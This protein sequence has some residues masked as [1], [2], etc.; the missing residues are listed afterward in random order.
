MRAM[1]KAHQADQRASINSGFGERR[2]LAFRLSRVQSLTIVAAGIAFTGL[3][4]YA[5][6][7]QVWFGPAYLAFICLA[8]WVLGWRE[9]VAGL[10]ATSIITV[11]V[12]SGE[13]YP[14]GAAATVWDYAIRIP[15]V[16]A[17]IALL[18]HARHT[19]EREWRLARTDPLTGAMNRKAFF[20]LAGPI[21]N[22]ESWHV[23]AY[24]DLD[25]LKSLNDEHGHEQGDESLKVFSSHVR[26]MI[27]KDDIFARVGGDEFLVY[28]AVRDAHAGLTVT[29]RLHRAMNAATDDSGA[30]LCCSVGALILAPG[31]RSI[32]REL[33]AADE[34]MYEAKQTGSALTAAI[35]REENG[36]LVTSGRW[37]M[38]GAMVVSQTEDR[39]FSSHYR[40]RSESARAGKAAA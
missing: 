30:G 34:L 37:L 11:A 1:G 4:D 29:N 25:G 23:L 31:P 26:S 8:A 33:R 14:Y 7:D 16:L 9:A 5:T 28:M 40:S 19:C 35:A 32:N 10:I 2:S 27:R 3:A 22:S 21:K 24:A 18:A 39:E 36:A 12:N 6:A 13:V 38:T 20:E 17:V 15:A